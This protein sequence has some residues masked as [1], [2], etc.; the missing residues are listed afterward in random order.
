[1][2]LGPVEVAAQSLKHVS[3]ASTADSCSQNTVAAMKTEA[4]VGAI[5]LAELSDT[6][7]Q[8]VHCCTTHIVPQLLSD[9]RDHKQTKAAKPSEEGAE[10]LKNLSSKGGN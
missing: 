1:M 4:E 5:L 2:A 10:L 7:Q 8:P 9:C 6:C 3:A